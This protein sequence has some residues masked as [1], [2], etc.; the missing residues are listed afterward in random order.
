MYYNKLIVQNWYRSKY[1]RS[2]Y[3]ILLWN[4]KLKMYVVIQKRKKSK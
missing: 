1:S 2:S 3:S 4:M